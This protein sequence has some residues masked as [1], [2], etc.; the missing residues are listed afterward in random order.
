MGEQAKRRRKVDRRRREPPFERVRVDAPPGLSAELTFPWVTGLAIG[1]APVPSASRSRHA[2][3]AP[4]R[5]R[6][7]AAE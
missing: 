3:L 5:R 4:P 6:H 7:R 2:P 1:A